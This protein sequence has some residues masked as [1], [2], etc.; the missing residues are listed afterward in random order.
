MYVNC[1]TTR[2]RIKWVSFSTGCL[3]R[4]LGCRLEEDDT[5]MLY[6]ETAT[7]EV[8]LYAAGLVKSSEWM[9]QLI[10]SMAADGKR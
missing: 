3:V 2:T 4:H 6:E 10:N 7:V 8:G 9:L 5:W 1:F